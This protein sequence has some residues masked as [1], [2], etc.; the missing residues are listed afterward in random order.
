M[1]IVH[2]PTLL[3]SIYS[4]TNWSI[5]RVDTHQHISVSI[6][7]VEMSDSEHMFYEFKCAS[8]QGC[9]DN[10]WLLKRGRPTHPFGKTYFINLRLGFQLTND[11]RP[12]EISN[13]RNHPCLNLHLC[14]CHTFKCLSKYSDNWPMSV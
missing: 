4:T 1:T 13:G 7:L 14:P 12:P 11:P 9:K 2:Q 5:H 8:K 6:R 3:T 10:E